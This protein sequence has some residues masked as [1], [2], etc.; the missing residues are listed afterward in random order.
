MAQTRTP[1]TRRDQN[2]SPHA[3]RAVVRPYVL[4]AL[5]IGLSCLIRG[6]YVFRYTDY[7]H[8]LV[9]DM[10]GYWVRA[11]EWMQGQ[12]QVHNQWAIWPPLYHILLGYAFQLFRSIHIPPP[13]WLASFLVAQIVLG[14]VSVYCLYGIAREM[15][16]HRVA[17]IIVGVL[18][19]LTYP[20]I[21]LNAFILSEN[22][23]LPLVIIAAYLVVRHPRSP[24]HLVAAGLLLGVSV[25]VRPAYVLFSAAFLIYALI[26]QGGLRAAARG[27]FFAA[28]FAAVTLCVCL[29]IS[30]MSHGRVK[31]LSANGGLNFFIMQCKL[32]HVESHYFVDG[33]EYTYV[34]I[35]PQFAEEQWRATYYTD[36]PP[37][38]PGYFVKKGVGCLCEERMWV[39][40]FWELRKLYFGTLFPTFSTAAGCMAIDPI[41]KVMLGVLTLAALLL[42]PVAWMVRRRIDWTAALF[43]SFIALVTTTSF[44]FGCERRYIYS[45]T[46]AVYPVL[47]SLFPPRAPRGAVVS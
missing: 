46:F 33:G 4:P 9:S 20:V 42:A 38:E 19:M 3:L 14:S 23:A 31:G 45:V 26:R 13:H 34:I 44:F 35:A 30:W 29:T 37:Y 25:G 11:I 8:Y 43:W 28:G 39:D 15:L 24:K 18:Y 41:C 7:H 17:A 1:L 27:L 32:L 36:H 47:A 10:G 21:Y 40:N 6:V 5:F 16:R 2:P 12:R 22:V